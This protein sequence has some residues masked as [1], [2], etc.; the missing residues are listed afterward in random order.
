MAINLYLFC[1]PSTR[2]KYQ[3][4]FPL[5]LRQ[6]NI[7]WGGLRELSYGEEFSVVLQQQDEV[8]SVVLVVACQGQYLQLEIEKLKSFSTDRQLT[9]S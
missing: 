3:T 5:S 1:Y 9:S 6:T 7:I 8:V 4:F 2:F